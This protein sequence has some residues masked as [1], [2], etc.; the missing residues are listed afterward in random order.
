ML[1]LQSLHLTLPHVLSKIHQ[2][3]KLFSLILHHMFLLQSF[4]LRL[5][6]LLLKIIQRLQRIRMPMWMN[7]GLVLHQ[8]W[9]NFSLV[10]KIMNTKNRWGTWLF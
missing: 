1:I 7:P 8:Q 6:L 4:L 10:L 9:G 5:P 3:R 2:L